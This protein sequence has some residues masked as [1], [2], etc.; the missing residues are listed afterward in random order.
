MRK[1]L[2][3]LAIVIA[4]IVT[5]SI[6][7]ISGGRQLSLFVDRFTTIETT[8][9]PIKSL[10]YEGSGTG[11]SLIL[12]PS[13]FQLN[14]SPADPHIES[15]HIGS[16]KDNQ[17]ALANAGKVFTFGPL[18]PSEKATL[19]SDIQAGDTA[20]L[21][22]KDSLL[23]WPNLFKTDRLLL[24]ERHR[25]WQLVWSKN[26][27]AK[28]EL[29]WRFEQHFDSHAVMTNDEAPGLIRVDISEGVR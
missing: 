4:L 12:L 3:T 19:A 23:P 2:I 17:M 22:C 10:A 8:S 26:S 9:T 24:W 13:G 18:R 27:G 11:G 21:T 28:L 5:M 29:L 16:T 6:V 14:L 20:S 15:P 7:W 25:Y 1:I